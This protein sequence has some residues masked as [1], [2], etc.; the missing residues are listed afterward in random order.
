MTAKKIEQVWC[1]NLH[2]NFSTYYLVLCTFD[3]CILDLTVS[4]FTWCCAL[5]TCAF[6]T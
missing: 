2:V 6:F 1:N 5:L 4:D 3:L